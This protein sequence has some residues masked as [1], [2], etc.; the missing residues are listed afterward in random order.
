MTSDVSPIANRI[1]TTPPSP[2][3]GPDLAEGAEELSLY[4]QDS[5]P[6]GSRPER[7]GRGAE[8]AVHSDYDGDGADIDVD[9][10]RLAVSKLQ[11][12]EAAR[13]RAPAI[14]QR[15][16]REH[17][18]P[19]AEGT[20]AKHEIHDLLRQ[21]EQGRRAGLVWETEALRQEA[22]HDADATTEAQAGSPGSATVAGETR[23]QRT[24]DL[25]THACGQRDLADVLRDLIAAMGRE[26]SRGTIADR[27]R[28]LSLLRSLYSLQTLATL[29][30]GCEALARRLAGSWSG[31][32]SM[33]LL[34]TAIRMTGST[35]TAADA[36]AELKREA[37][38]PGPQ[39]W[40]TFLSGLR[41]LVCELPHYV[42]ATAAAREQVIEQL[43]DDVD[44]AVFNV[45]T[46]LQFTREQT[47]V[48]PSNSGS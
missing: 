11:D 31:I 4:K 34:R 19:S 5:R 46:G 37:G 18:G 43:Q 6:P 48:H 28:L 35:G 45:E 33:A 44:L 1:A 25:V 22:L 42:F 36:C 12:A 17:E 38:T 23:L 20:T 26:L 13:Q 10:T 39:G 24:L 27:Y 41:M 3:T 16:L 40:L 2:A 9:A 7:K 32:G 29:H 47:A 8:P 14:L 21:L 30:E 15:I